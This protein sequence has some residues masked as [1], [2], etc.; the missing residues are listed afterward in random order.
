MSRDSDQGGAWRLLLSAGVIALAVLVTVILVAQPDNRVHDVLTSRH[1]ETPRF[2]APPP[3]KPIGETLSHLWSDLTHRPGAAFLDRILPTESGGLWIALIV[4]LVVGFDTSKPRNPRNLELMALLVVGF[5]LFD[6]MRFFNLLDDPFYF[7]VM[8]WVFTGVVAT[9]L[10]LA[11]RAAWRVW[12]P[13]ITPWQPNLPTRAL[14]LLT[15]VLFTMNALV[16]I[17]RAP[18]DAGFYTNL[19]GQRLRERGMFP[20]GDPLITGSP[21]AA[22]GPVLF[23][24]H[25]PFQWLFDRAPINPATDHPLEENQVYNLPP[26]QAS[27][28]ATLTFHLIAVAALVVGARR[29]AGDQVAWALA[30]LY[31][32]SA[33]VLGVG[34]PPE[35]VNGLTFISHTAPPALAL[36]AFACLP[37]PLLAGVFLALSVATVFYPLFFIPAWIGYYLRTRGAAVRFVA[38]MALAAIVVGG[39]VLALSRPIE[40]HGLVGTIVR[41]TLGHHQGSDTYGLTPFG[42]WGQRGGVRAWMQEELIK[43][44]ATTTPMFLVAALLAALAFFP[45]R[46][47]TPQQLALLSGASAILVEVWKIL[48]TGVYV[49]WYFPFLL[50]GFFAYGRAPSLDPAGSE[51]PAGVVAV[52]Q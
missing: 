27:Q 13:N 42:F 41:E 16:V 40:G 23:L 18:D 6:V 43:G 46:R 17:V 29:L 47:A 34:G 39:P 21:A 31:C 4:A 8:D 50:L 30:A 35:M 33:Y 7:R 3:L 12:R 15:L 5:L 49:T 25:I 36:V 10:W 1:L 51:M 37:N 26:A 32:G 9:S 28:L 52:G 11:A 24:A 19:G 22:Y 38:G 2:H 48:G 45:A 44:Q 14:M 20:Y